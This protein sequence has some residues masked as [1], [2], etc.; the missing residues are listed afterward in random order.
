MRY[1]G[2]VMPSHENESMNQKQVATSETSASARL[3]G[4]TEERLLRLYRE[5]FQKAEETRRWNLWND[6]AWD[7]VPVD[8]NGK[9]TETPAEDTVDKTEVPRKM[10]HYLSNNPPPELAES[11]LAAYREDLFL[12]DYSASALHFLRASRGRAWFLTRWSYEEGKHLLALGQWLVLSGTLADSDLRDLSNA[13]LAKYEWQ[14]A[15]DDAPFIFADSLLWEMHEIDRFRALRKA[16]EETGD[17]ALSELATR[18]LTDEEA[19]R[20]FFRLGLAII[21]ERYPD[22]VRD[23]V[24]RAA[25]AHESPD[26]GRALLALLDI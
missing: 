1:D 20:D 24:A 17:N 14:P 16:A 25:Q 2:N 12:P 23:A 18:I 19:H 22:M 15:H 26:A 9:P 3:D 21:A 10:R 13:L 4:A 7:A 11:V 5:F 8:A 6:I